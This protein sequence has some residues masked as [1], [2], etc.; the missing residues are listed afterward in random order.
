MNHKNRRKSRQHVS[1]GFTFIELLAA[2]VILIT[3]GGIVVSIFVS[4]LRNTTKTNTITIVRQNGNFAITHMSRM[5]R[6]ARSFDGV[7]IDDTSYQS[8]CVVPTPGGG[9]PT[10]TPSQYQQVKF[11][12]H[13][14]GQTTFLCSYVPAENPSEPPT[15]AS[16]SGSSV[17]SSFLD[18]SAVSITTCYF[19][20]TQNSLSDYPI[21]GIH[22]QLQDQRGTTPALFP[23]RTATIPFTTSVTMRNLFR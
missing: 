20:C 23:E 17:P 2:I 4:S 21:V 19:T 12:A 16:R 10:P 8:N 1:N 13:D 14:G 6:F 5:L 3:I 7:S 22:F 18:T 15:I 9:T 11:T